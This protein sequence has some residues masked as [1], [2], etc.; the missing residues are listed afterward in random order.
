M[1]SATLVHPARYPSIGSLLR[2]MVGGAQRSGFHVELRNHRSGRIVAREPA[3]DS[4]AQA[5]A[6]LALIAADLRTLTLEEFGK[7]WG[8]QRPVLR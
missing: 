4:E 1:L 8:R 7:R 6:L 3:G 5:R 2:G